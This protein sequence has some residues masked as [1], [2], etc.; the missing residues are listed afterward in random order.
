[1][2]DSIQLLLEKKNWTGDDVGKAI[3]YSAIDSYGQTLQGEA[4]PRELF[5]SGRLRQMVSAIKGQDQLRRYNRYV[6]LNNWLAQYHAVAL[7]YY[8]QVDGEIN[9]LLGIVATAAAVED[10]YKYIERLPVIMT[11]KQYDEIKA[12]RIEEQLRLDGQQ[13]V[14]ALIGSAVSYFIDRLRREPK[15]PNP[16]RRIKKIYQGERVK[17]VRVLRAMEKG[18]DGEVSKWDALAIG[19]LFECY[20]AMLGESGDVEEADYIAQAEDFK[21]EFPELLDAVAKEIDRRFFEGLEGVAE[22]PIKKWRS[23]S[24]TVRELYDLDFFGLRERIESD[25]AVFDGDKRILMN[26]VAILKPSGLFSGTFEES[27]LIDERGHYVEP[28]RL[29]GLGAVCGLEQ[30]TAANEEY[31]ENIE[32]L[33]RGRSIIE[34]GYYYL[35]GY[36]RAIDL[37]AG[38]IG[39]QEF[40][41]FK[42][43]PE[44]IAGR[45]EALNNLTALMYARAQR[46]DYGG[47]D[48][49]LDVLRE[50]FRPIRWSEFAIPEDAVAQA[51][52]LLNDNMK[53][54]EAQDGV[55][56]NLLATRR[57]GA[58]TWQTKRAK[59]P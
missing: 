28:E 37:I 2:L 47:P 51:R 7:A 24:F 33:E 12:R 40:T 32:R 29:S 14:F 39:I 52:E 8:Q 27:P 46:A 43:G 23:V 21:A 1:M 11:Q 16:V 57:E 18:E 30:F 59:Q 56:I 41:V 22:L 6:G 53:A 35:L 42:M 26:G 4:N 36:D 44:T 19:D 49:K 38:Y 48:A 31:R 13:S 20:P 50:Y 17:S 34:D 45:I 25:T 54:F 9:R 3:I 55:F 15:K 5:S 58:Y 10:E